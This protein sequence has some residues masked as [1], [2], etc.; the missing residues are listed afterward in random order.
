MK[1][2]EN[3]CG[4]TQTEV[5]AYMKEYLGSKGYKTVDED[6]FLYAKGTVPVLLVAH[7]DTVH[8]ERCTDIVKQDGEWS[9]PQGIGGDDRC[10]I[11]IIM[12]IVKELKCSVLLCEDEE[13]GCIGARKFTK[14]TY[15]LKNVKGDDVT[16]KYI[17]TLDVNYMIE[18]DRKG[19]NDAVFYSCDNKEF[20]N[21]V[22]DFT[23]YKVQ[24]GSLSDISILMP[25]AK[26]A[27]V[28]LSCGYY[29]PHTLKEYVVYDEMMD[30]VEAAKTLIKEK[31][32][33]PF[34]YIARKYEYTPYKPSTNVKSLTN[35][36]K[37]PDGMDYYSSYFDEFEHKNKSLYNLAIKDKDIELE[38]VVMD[39]DNGENVLYA[40]GVSKPECWMNLF[41][42]NP[43]I[44]FNDI[45]D[46]TWC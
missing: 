23:G 22:T 8:Q 39:L 21:F 9:S 29:N 36:H 38:V 28:N 34:E 18:F 20:T 1:T 27:A 19:S 10:G 33:E 6:G 42:D 24:W 44:C 26:L 13:K 43:T 17:N 11:F 25:E 4:M 45:V 35:Y 3:I 32:D 12:N 30:T 5:K 41:L 37:D 31:C 40:N 14:A 15:T 46:F 2:F 16:F 7:M